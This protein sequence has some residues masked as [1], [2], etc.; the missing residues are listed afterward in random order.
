LRVANLTQIRPRPDPFRGASGFGERKCGNR[1]K[2]NR[3]AIDVQQPRDGAVDLFVPV[4]AIVLEDDLA[5]W[6]IMYCAGQYWLR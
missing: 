2:W 5:C 4:L 3:S 6:S 1:A